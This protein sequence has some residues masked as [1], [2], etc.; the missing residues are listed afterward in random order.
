MTAHAAAPR[1]PAGPTTA[2]TQDHRLLDALVRAGLDW[3]EERC[4]LFRLPP[5]LTADNNVNFTLKPLGELAELTGVIAAA[6]PRPE[7]RAQATR[8]RAFAWTQTREGDLFHELIRAEP[9]ATYP[10]ELYGVFA[11]SGLRHRAV[12]ELA[13]TTTRLRGWQIAREDHTRTLGILNAERRIGL[14]PH[15]CRDTVFAHTGLGIQPEPW[16]VDRL[17]AYGITHD[18]FHLTD[19][20]RDR[21][22]LPPAAATYLRPWAP[23]W[24]RI[25]LEE[26]FWDLAGEMLAV[27][28]CLPDAP[29]DQAAWQHLAAAQ[30]ADGSIAETGTT[31]RPTDPERLFTACYHSTLVAVFA[32]TLARTATA[33]PTPPPHPG[34]HHAG[35]PA[36]QPK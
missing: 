7:L 23:A 18:V 21:P 11:R 8:L 5:D 25:W 13:A 33:Q 29:F 30:A 20:G 2:A 27:T 1:D 35:P 26:Q 28:A 4:D 6:H 19:W 12:E 15:T 17:T 3:L 24:A 32:A 34:P 16:A 36:H 10:V 31:P 9:Y 22:A 14:P